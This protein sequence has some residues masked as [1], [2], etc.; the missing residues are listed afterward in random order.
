MLALTASCFPGLSFRLFEA[1][2]V[3][4]L[5][6]VRGIHFPL[7]CPVFFLHLG[8]FFGKGYVGN[9]LL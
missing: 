2:I 6:V 1:G 5:V 7:T 4:L 8:Q 3:R 9:A